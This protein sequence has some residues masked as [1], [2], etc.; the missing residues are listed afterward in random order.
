MVLGP[1]GC[2]KSAL[3][4]RFG[5]QLV[6]RGTAVLAIKADQLRNG[7]DSASKLA[8]R[9]DLPVLTD[10]AVFAVAE[11]EPVIVLFDQLDALADLADLS[12]PFHK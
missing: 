9:L 8:E 6:G 3:L 5:Q 12:G 2:G 7:V 4:A 11:V 10:Q 1:P